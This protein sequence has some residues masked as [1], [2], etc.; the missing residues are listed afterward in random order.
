MLK[1]KL[2][3]KIDLIDAEL[4]LDKLHFKRNETAIV[5]HKN[6]SSFKLLY[7]GTRSSTKNYFDSIIL[8][9]SNYE[10]GTTACNIFL[11]SNFIL[12]DDAIITISN[13]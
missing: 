8:S 9:A 7:T 4:T 6:D 12:D 5:K 13:K 3:T 10:V 2:K 11:L 1:V